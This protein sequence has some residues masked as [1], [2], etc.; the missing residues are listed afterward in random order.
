MF[1]SNLFS[2]ELFKKKDK[3]LFD[4]AFITPRIRPGTRW[5]WWIV[6][7]RLI[8]QWLIKLAC[9][10]QTHP[11]KNIFSSKILAITNDRQVASLNF[12]TLISKPS[13]LC[14]PAYAA[15]GAEPWWCFCQRALLLCWFT[16]KCNSVISSWKK[17]AASSSACPQTS[18][19]SRLRRGDCHLP[20]PTG[21]FFS[22]TMQAQWAIQSCWIS[23]QLNIPCHFSENMILS[24]CKCTSLER[25]LPQCQT[26][27]FL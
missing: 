10:L 19:N 16:L 11:H 13:V 5:E 20:N 1:A 23:N 4:C 2:H 3:I 15:T 24:E 21:W 18:I 17:N 22:A 14:L 9:L 6:A 12:W 7:S 8:T 25:I 26:L 27:G